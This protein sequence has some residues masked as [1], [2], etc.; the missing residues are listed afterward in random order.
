MSTRSFLSTVNFES[1][2]SM[3]KSSIDPFFY[4]IEPISSL[5]GYAIK[6]FVGVNNLYNVDERN[7][8]L[9]I[10]EYRFS[11]TDTTPT[12]AT[13]SNLLTM[14]TG[15]YTI[16]NYI[17]ALQD[18][19][20]FNGT[21]GNA[22][23]ITQN[24]TNN[25]LMISTSSTA[26]NFI[27]SSIGNS[28]YYNIGVSDS[29]LSTL[30][31]LGNSSL[32]ANN[33]YDLSGTK[34]LHVVSNDFGNRFSFQ[35]TNNHN[36]ILSIPLDESYMSVITAGQDSFITNTLSQNISNF[37]FRLFDEKYRPIPNYFNDWF[38]S[39]YIETN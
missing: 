1:E 20:N 22:Y 16:T 9:L 37:Q 13:S 29:Q 34:C 19:L 4:M 23:T 7:N 27:L 24:T 12:I 35:S 5:S 15:N 38:M 11:I 28:L 3:N 36:T 14:T 18:T 10:N 17:T 39:L 30:N 26:E 21:N 31:T 8:K 2:Q 32:T 33:T 25:H 6:N